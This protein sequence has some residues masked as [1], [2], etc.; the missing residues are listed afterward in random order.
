MG[1]TPPAAGLTIYTRL[2]PDRAEPSRR[3]TDFV[4]NMS[5][6]IEVSLVELTASQH[7]TAGQ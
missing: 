6:A 4:T 7:E 1:G 5:P 2:V 3:L